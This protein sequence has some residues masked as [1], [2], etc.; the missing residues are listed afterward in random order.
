MVALTLV[1][2]LF[3][4]LPLLDF[5]TTK[6]RAAEG[7]SSCARRWAHSA[8]CVRTSSW[9]A[10]CTSIWPLSTFCSRQERSFARA[11]AAASDSPLTATVPPLFCCLTS[12]QFRKRYFHA[13]AS[14]QVF[15]ESKEVD[16]VFAE[17]SKHMVRRFGVLSC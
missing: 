3:G 12:P 1:A 8:S 4:S 5:R 9:T 16:S 14:R 7:L 6:V 17:M 15:M 11:F 13:N 2:V 10:P